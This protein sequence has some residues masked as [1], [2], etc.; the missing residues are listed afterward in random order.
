MVYM[1]L[2]LCRLAFFSFLCHVLLQLLHVCF[3]FIPIC[4]LF[5]FVVVVVVLIGRFIHQNDI[6]SIPK[7]AFVG[8]KSL[9][10]L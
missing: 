5:F 1:F 6:R 10:Y 7:G 2:F 9:K 8:L 4:F 3:C